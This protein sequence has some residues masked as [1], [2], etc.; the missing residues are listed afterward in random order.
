MLRIR[1]ERIHY[2]TDKGLVQGANRLMPSADNI[3][4]GVK[5]MPQDHSNDP[6]ND[7]GNLDERR[8]PTNNNDDSATID[9]PSLNPGFQSE[10]RPV[11]NGNIPTIEGVANVKERFPSDHERLMSKIDLGD[12]LI[13]RENTHSGRFER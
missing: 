10:E 2:Y 1:K 9:R 5:Y 7:A 4:E 11:P 6:F 13:K 12:A 8:D 3:S